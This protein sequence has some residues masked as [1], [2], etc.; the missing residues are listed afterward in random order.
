MSGTPSSDASGDAVTGALRARWLGTVPYREALALQ[1]GLFAH[2][3]ED[4]LI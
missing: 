1:Q 4:L 3:C 2:G